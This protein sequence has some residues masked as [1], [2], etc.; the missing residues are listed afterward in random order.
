M[1]HFK[2]IGIAG[3]AIAASATVATYRASAT[4]QSSVPDANGLTIEAAYTALHD[5]GY[6]VTVQSNHQTFSLF[7]YCS[8][9]V[10]HEQ[11]AAGA[12]AARGRTVSL[13]IGRCIGNAPKHVELRRAIL[14]NFVGNS[15][16]AMVHWA[17]KNGMPWAARNLPT[18]RAAK[19]PTL[20]G[21]F[22]I[23]KQWPAPGRAQ[24]GVPG[25]SSGLY[26][27]PVTSWSK[28]SR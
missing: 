15:V 21:N 3:L 24:S 7:W 14:P 28:L 22:R 19:A 26:P 6:A 13:T 9:R 16:I 2:K 1:A 11:P 8:P 18:I 23:L 25:P 17:K 10:T 27:T 4:A 5:A 12:P 20:L